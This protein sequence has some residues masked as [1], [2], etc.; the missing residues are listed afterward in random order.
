MP[1]SIVSVEIL[2]LQWNNFTLPSL[3][4]MNSH[5]IDIQSYSPGLNFPVQQPVLHGDYV[6]ATFLHAV[7]VWNWVTSD[8]FIWQT[9]PTISIAHVSLPILSFFLRRLI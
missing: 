1:L 6:V 9:P 2:R 5:T 8:L 4:A 7:A 3:E